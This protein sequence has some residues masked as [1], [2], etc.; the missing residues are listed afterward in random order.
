MKISLWC[1]F[2]VGFLHILCAGISK[3]KADYDNRNPRAWLAAQK[4]FR[5]RANSAQQNSWEAFLWFAVAI[6]VSQSMNAIDNTTVEFLALAFVILRTSYIAAYVF[7]FA[8]LRTI[9][10]SAAFLANISIF[11]I[12]IV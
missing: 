10:W 7:N 2:Y 3:S 6:L 1:L 12:A 9:F 8:I 11:V 4:G 5:S